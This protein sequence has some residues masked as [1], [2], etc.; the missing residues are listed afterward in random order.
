M[1]NTTFQFTTRDEIYAILT[2]CSS[3]LSI[4]G[5]VGIIIIYVYFKDLRTCGRKL[6][7]YLSLMDALT[8]FGNILGVVWLLCRAGTTCRSV[9]ESM[10]F[11]RLHASLTIF[12]SI[13]S[14]L[15]MV[16]IGL[17]AVVTLSLG[18]IGYDKNIASWC[19]I[20]PDTPAILFWQFFTGKA[21]E[22]S[23]YLLT[24][25]M[26]SVVRGFL[27]KHANKSLAVSKKKSRKAAL[28]EANL[29]LTFV[30][31]VFIVL[32]VWGT[33]RFLLGSLAHYDAPWISYLQGVG[34]SSQ[35]FA[36]FILYCAL[37]DKVRE[38]VFAAIFLRKPNHHS[39]GDNSRRLRASTVETQPSS[40]EVTWT[41][42][43]VN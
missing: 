10:E 14:F 39:T 21:W 24:I 32:R 18:V 38:R 31:V 33:L 8:A 12:S 34:D 30:P 43:V 19:W 17:V 13:S 6:L 35:G 36:N 29:K 25:V 15:W 26:Y 20:D 3:S 4:F 2:V 37:T 1:S 22:M 7:V 5:G 42:E 41:E 28:Q 27:F 9:Y 23:T 11:C 16:I 40:H